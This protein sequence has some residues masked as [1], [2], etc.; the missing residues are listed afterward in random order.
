MSQSPSV[1]APKHADGVWVSPGLP[2]RLQR[3]LSWGA[4]GDFYESGLS[5][6]ALLLLTSRGEE[7]GGKDCNRRRGSRLTAAAVL[8]SY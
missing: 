1:V 6:S 8:C 7:R 3:C 2:P 4:G 5:Y